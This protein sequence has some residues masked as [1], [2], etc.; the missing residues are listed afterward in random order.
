MPAGKGVYNAPWEK[1]FDRLLTPLEE[2]NQYFDT[3]LTHDKVETIAGL[4]TSELGHVPERGEEVTI[5]HFHFNIITS[6][7][8]SSCSNHTI[9]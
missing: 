7:N 5:D 8:F 3:D 9:T 1:S 2:F 6:R 4:V